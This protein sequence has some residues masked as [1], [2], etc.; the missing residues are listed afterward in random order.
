VNPAA[1]LSIFA[2][3][4]ALVAGTAAVVGNATQLEPPGG[5][6]ERPGHGGGEEME[7]AATS[8]T[9]D[10]TRITADGLTLRPN[11]TV[12][13][14]G[15]K[16]RWSF[17]IL[18]ADGDPVREFKPEQSKLL[19]LILVRS[20]LTGFQHLHPELKSDGTFVVSFELP[21]PGRY[22]AIVDFLTTDDEKHVLGTDLV[23]G[24]ST[25]ERPL[26]PVSQTASVDGYH[27]TLETPEE[28]TAGEE[29]HLDFHVEQAGRPVTDLQPYLGAYGHLV[30]L[31]APS[32]AYSH[33]HPTE[34]DL[35][36]GS[37]SFGAELMEPGNYRLFL[38]FRAGGS[39]HTAEFTLE[40]R[41]A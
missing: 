36:Q 1:K 40:A 2:I 13:E 28:V 34:E 21:D 6:K 25:S 41:S 37:I 22:R 30:A 27:V 38:Q 12:I 3:A 19:H 7:M 32:V 39:V 4:L 29:S 26:P 5:G 20:D 17:Q 9:A 11:T 24:D 16:T 14:P 8:S 23:A 31:H 33:V 18:T 15:E 35:E 10:G